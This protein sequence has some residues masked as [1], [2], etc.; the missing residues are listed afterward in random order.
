MNAMYFTKKNSTQKRKDL[1]KKLKS[2]K[3]L[4]FPGAYN[5]LTAKL[6]YRNK[7]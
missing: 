6:N 4:K 2:K 1:K 3:L 7:F 5:P